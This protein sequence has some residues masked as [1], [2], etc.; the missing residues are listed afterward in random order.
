MRYGPEIYKAENKLDVDVIGLFRKRV[1]RN[2]ADLEDMRSGRTTFASSDVFLG[3]SVNGALRAMPSKSCSFIITS[4]PYPCEHDYTRLTR[5]ELVFSGHVSEPSH[6]RAIK[7]RLI[8]CCTRNIYS[9]DSLYKE[10]SR[11]GTLRSVVQ[12]I[13]RESQN[14][15]HG[16]ARLYSRVVEEYFGGMYQHFQEVSRVLRPGGRCAY[17][18][19]DQASF[20]SIQIKTAELLARLATSRH[21]GLKEIDCI[22]LRQLKSPT[23]ANQLMN[24]EW[25]LVLGKD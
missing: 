13:K 10:I 22:R 15:T 24:H 11:F 6:L 7:Q 12:A 19:G 1:A 21:V 9:G 20:F 25:L 23:G 3:D 14:H 4:P 17:I 16:F 5:L 18:V 2:L 8:R